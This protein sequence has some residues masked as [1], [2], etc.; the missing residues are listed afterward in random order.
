[1]RSHGRVRYAGPNDSVYRPIALAVLEGSMDKCWTATAAAPVWRVTGSTLTAKQLRTR[2]NVARSG[3][4][5]VDHRVRIV[6]LDQGSQVLIGA[7]HHVDQQRLQ[8]DVRDLS[9]DIQQDNL[10]AP[11]DMF[12]DHHR[13]RYRHQHTD[14]HQ[15]PAASSHTGLRATP[16]ERLRRHRASAPPVTVCHVLA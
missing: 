12:G 11:S 14:G 3:L 16:I 9:G 5:V 2:L 1:M 13:T 15:T 8:P 6:G 4:D 10:D 7:R